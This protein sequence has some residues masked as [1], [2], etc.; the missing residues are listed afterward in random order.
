MP[1]D[2][3]IK[4]LTRLRNL[5]AVLDEELQCR[6]ANRPSERPSSPSN[7]SDDGNESNVK[8]GSIPTIDEL[9][10]LSARLKLAQANLISAQQKWN[11]ILEH[12]AMYSAL[13]NSQIPFPE[14]P[15][16][17]LSTTFL[18]K[19]LA[20]IRFY[21]GCAYY[22]WMTYLRSFTYRILAFSTAC[23]SLVVLWSETTMAI[24]FNLS[25]F[26]YALRIF[27]EDGLESGILFKI[28]ALIPLLY[29]SACVYTSLFKVS[30]F[31]PNC[32]RGS[33]QSP[34]VA[35]VFNAQYLIRMQF[36]LGFNYLNM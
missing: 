24:P 8:D 6:R 14:K 1:H 36:P 29:M 22:G 18:E 20:G 12:N 10:M 13:V 5:T 7:A 32:L 4:E 19:M 11:L 23:L 25:P 26:H 31:G 2:D 16:H 21:K 17:S 35:L 30:F 15:Q 27:D 3:C 28:S 34:G 33:K 9:A